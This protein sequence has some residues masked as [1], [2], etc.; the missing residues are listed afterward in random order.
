MDIDS[1]NTFYKEDFISMKKKVV[2][3]LLATAMVA[4]MAGCGSNDAATTGT[5]T[6]AATEEAAPAAEESTDAAAEE[7]TDDAAA[8]TDSASGDL[9]YKGSI[10]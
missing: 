8:A 9:A 10:L 1:N 7:T 2:S 6:S 5:D 3:M 4:T